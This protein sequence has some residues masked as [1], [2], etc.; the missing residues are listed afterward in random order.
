LVE[1]HLD[2][3][4]FG[5]WAVDLYAGRVTRPHSDI[6]VAIWYEDLEQINTLLTRAD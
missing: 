1:H 2:Y 3:W 6:D 4:V 5:G